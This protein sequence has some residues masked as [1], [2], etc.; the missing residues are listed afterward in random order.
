MGAVGIPMTYIGMYRK[1]FNAFP[2]NVSYI[3]KVF[4]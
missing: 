1:A 4:I 3:L 2:E